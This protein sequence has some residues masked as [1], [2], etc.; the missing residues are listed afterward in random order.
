MKM[1]DDGSNKGEIIH[2][3]QHDCQQTPIAVA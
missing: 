1:A 3:N 2:I